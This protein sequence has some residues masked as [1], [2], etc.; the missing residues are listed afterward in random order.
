[1]NLITRFIYELQGIGMLLGRMFRGLRKQPRYFGEIVTQ[2][3]RIGVGSLGIVILTGFFTGGVLILQAYPTLQVLRCPEQRRARRRNNADPRAWARVNGIDGRRQSR[4]VDIGG[5]R[6]DGRLA[7]DRRDAGT[8]HFPVRKLVTP[9]VIALILA[10]P[11]LTV[12][13]DIFGLIGGGIIAKQIYGLDASVY[14]SSVRAG[15]DIDDLIG[16]DHQAPDLRV[17]HWDHLLLQGA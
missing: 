2:L 6:F 5:T 10:L 16:G 3:D 7:A 12:A 17:D 11:L 8:W 13:S 1:M 15:V 14:T 9:R 4:F